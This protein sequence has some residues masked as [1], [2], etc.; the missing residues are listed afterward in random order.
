MQL[1]R[2]INNVHKDNTSRYYLKSLFLTVT[3][4]QRVSDLLLVLIS[5]PNCSFS[6]LLVYW[7]DR[8]SLGLNPLACRPLALPTASIL[9]H[10]SY[11]L[12]ALS[13]CCPSQV[14]AW[15]LEE[16][17]TLNIDFQGEVSWQKKDLHRLVSVFKL[18]YI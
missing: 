18:K 5:K 3:N 8:L 2:S 14:E 16:E 10:S 4:I 15:V 11:L 6:D 1:G 13:G 17:R 12:Q 9:G 7:L